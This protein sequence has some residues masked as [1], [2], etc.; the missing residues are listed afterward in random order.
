MGRL[1]DE[2]AQVVIVA[3]SADIV[4]DGLNET[5]RVVNEVKDP[6][7]DWRRIFEVARS[8]S[9]FAGLLPPIYDA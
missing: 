4:M 9:R 1:L 8:T 5:T 7:L 2:G 3:V 6:R